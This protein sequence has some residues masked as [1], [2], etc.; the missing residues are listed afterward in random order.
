M[1]KHNR[2]GK[3]RRK[4]DKDKEEDINA[5]AGARLDWR[6]RIGVDD[7][8]LHSVDSLQSFRESY[9]IT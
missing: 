3:T 1:I 7:W 2:I 4:E 5:I 8:S 6:R 9:K